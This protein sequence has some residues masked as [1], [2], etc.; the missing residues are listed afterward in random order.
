MVSI[1]VREALKLPELKGLQ[2][3]AGK[4]GL[5]R[6]IKNVTVI[7]VPSPA[8]HLKEGDLLLTS[9]Y[10][11]KGDELGKLKL[12][13]AISRLQ[14]AGLC[15]HPESDT[16]ISDDLIKV[17]NSE[18][19]PIFRMPKEMSYVEVIASIYAAIFN[20]Q[21]NFLARSTEISALLTK[22]ILSGE[23]AENI[24]KIVASFIKNPI[25][26]LDASLNLIIGEPYYDK[27]EFLIE[28]EIKNLINMNIIH[29]HHFIGEA[30]LIK[31][32]NI[33]GEQIRLVIYNIIVKKSLYGYLII[34]EAHK[35]LDEI[36]YNALTYAS[37]AIALDFMRTSNIEEQHKNNIRDFW[38]DVFSD[39]SL[40]AESIIKKGKLL[41]LNIAPLNNVMIVK[42][43]KLECN[44]G[45]NIYECIEDSALINLIAL[46]IK[47][48]AD[49]YFPLNYLH[50]NSEGIIIIFQTEKACDRKSKILELAAQI[51]STLSKIKGNM[52]VF[53]GNGS[54]ARSAKEIKLS[55][56]HA[57]TAIE[58]AKCIE[59]MGAEV[60]YDDLG[61]NKFIWIVAN[62]LLMKDYIDLVLPDVDKCNSSIIETLEV[63]LE[64]NKSITKASK[65]LYVHPNTVKIRLKKAKQLLG[66]DILDDKCWLDTLICLKLNKFNCK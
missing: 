40:S 4:Q 19:F 9:F 62:N 5:E 23:K 48:L 35:L 37:T 52:I 38:E 16:Q 42:I 21:A 27:N 29:E 10:G 58:I 13:R 63:Y 53:I 31:E 14:T 59:P 45:N 11:L 3:I 1:T 18:R 2:I 24:V 64:C 36:D 39:T 8:A 30:P 57:N 44:K 15:I 55:F 20:R 33:N 65:H 54:D 60:N 22:T 41:G 61:I 46:R 28:K 17:A 47:L 66:E 34:W 50:L 6:E 25:A 49:K 12:I 51:R 7:E 56:A 32:C 26:L 43:G